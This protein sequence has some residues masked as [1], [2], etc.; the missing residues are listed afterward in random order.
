MLYKQGNY[1]RVLCITRNIVFPLE[2]L[3]VDNATSGILFQWERSVWLYNIKYVFLIA[4]QLKLNICVINHYGCWLGTT[5]TA[6]ITWNSISEL[7][8]TKMHLWQS[9]QLD[10]YWSTRMPKLKS[11]LIK[12]CC[13]RNPA[14]PSQTG[15]FAK[16][17]GGGVRAFCE[18]LA[19]ILHISIK[20]P[21]SGSRL[22]QSYSNAD[23]DWEPG[24]R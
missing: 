15:A 19:S 5:Q 22:T 12:P 17:E 2:N 13:T 16:G 8:D 23:W 18:L 11:K 9:R 24:M 1:F 7:Q 3:G 14:P 21:L 20:N 4:I 6:Q 10:G